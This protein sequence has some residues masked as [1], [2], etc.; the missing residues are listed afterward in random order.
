MSPISPT[1]AHVERAL[2]DPEAQPLSRLLDERCDEARV[3]KMWHGLERPRGPARQRALFALAAALSVLVACSGWLWVGRAA[4][5]PLALRAG[6]IPSVLVGG[7]QGAQVA[8]G[9][10]SE[11]RL[12][13]GAR[14]EVLRNDGRSFVTV[15]R[16]GE[17]L[18]DVKPGGP[19][20]W[21]IEAGLAS[22]EVLGTRFR[23][24][25]GVHSVRVEVERGV[26]S[27]RG[28]A[29]PGGSV[30]LSAGMRSELREPVP[31]PKVEASAPARVVEEP[32]RSAV[33]SAGA[34]S[35][36]LETAPSAR[37]LG[38]PAP[39]VSAPPAHETSDAIDE[40]LA[41]ADAARRAGDR[42]RAMRLLEA[43]LQR[44]RSRDPRRGLAALSLARLSLS[45][46]P[47]RAA[48]AL[49]GSLDAM[50][51]ALSED[52]L[53]RQVEAIGRSG[54]RA[55]AAELA[56]RYLQRFPH[57]QRTKEV[58]RWLAP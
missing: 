50:P 46:E 38:L 37:A 48:R 12:S 35:S 42:E 36:S 22:V 23:V 5:H 57:G 51:S 54:R 43:V 8:L 58:S 45:D 47:S 31:S 41:N 15:L 52:A 40:L 11:L 27:V 9:D 39:S 53:A 33:E 13:A 14:L 55:E 10:G 4:N 20:K 29:V 19:R 1:R 26:V 32:S 7:A 16:R 3:L 56:R 49:A 18:F 24:V 28:E 34:P 30:R 21:V 17:G 2:A 44:A 6:E 25:R